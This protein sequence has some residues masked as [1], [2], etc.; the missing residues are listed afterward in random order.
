MRR[1][2]F[3]LFLPALIGCSQNI[4]MQG[5][6]YVDEGQYDRAIESFYKQITVNPK[7]AVA[8]REIGIA[9]YKK[10]DFIKAE[11]A[12]KQAN[13]IAPDASSNL[14]IGMIYEQGNEIDKAID[15]YTA[16]LNLEPK[17]ETRRLIQSHLDQLV[18]ARLKREASR[19]IKNEENIKASSIPENTVAVV[20]FDGSHLP[21][22]LAPLSD[23]FAEFTASDL[24][25]VQSL[26]VVDRMKIDAILNELKLSSSQYADP[27]TAPRLGRIIGSRRVVT[28]SVLNVGD[29]GLRIDGAIVNTVDSSAEMTGT[30]EGELKTFF[31]VQKDFVFKVIDDLGI[32]LTAAERDSIQKVPTESYL[33]FM[34]YCR[35]LDYKKRGMYGQARAEFSQAAKADGNFQEAQTQFKSTPPKAASGSGEGGFGNFQSSVSSQTELEQISTIDLQP[36]LQDLLQ[37]TGAVRDWIER[38]NNLVPPTTSGTGTVVIRGDI[39]AH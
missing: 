39:D 11:D 9:N 30:T 24:S 8:W 12:F 25:K 23:G 17:G 2:F 28:G 37:N 7:D 5:R 27:A 21:A 4:Y 26:K 18:T 15:A 3:I 19:A 14:Y 34:A 13:Q 31:K 38:H 29:Q 1:L 16:S 22:N 6:R 33:A 36:R 32:K 20:D 35:G 10:G